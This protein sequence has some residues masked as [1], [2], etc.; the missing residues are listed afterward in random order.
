MT[1]VS[2]S[3][4]L[5]FVNKPEIEIVMPPVLDYKARV[6]ISPL[7]TLKKAWNVILLVMGISSLDTYIDRPLLRIALVLIISS[8]V[9]STKTIFSEILVPMFLV[10]YQLEVLASMLLS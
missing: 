6:L 5:V 9:K 7:C 1:K 4:A 2:V 8:S 10:S 3:K